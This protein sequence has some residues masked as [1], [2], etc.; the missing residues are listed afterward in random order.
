MG[1]SSSVSHSHHGDLG[2]CLVIDL[3]AHAIELLD[4]RRRHHMS[5]IADVIGRFGKALDR[6]AERRYTQNERRQNRSA[7]C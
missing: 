7:A 5:E 2:V 1:S 4:Y 3:A 6:L